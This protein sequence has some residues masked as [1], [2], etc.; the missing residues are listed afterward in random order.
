MSKEI[1]VDF[2]VSGRTFSIP[3]NYTIEMTEDIETISCRVVTNGYHPP[4][5][6]AMRSFEFRSIVT[7]GMH[8]P[9]FI[10]NDHIKN[11]NAELFTDKVFDTIMAEEHF[12]VHE[13]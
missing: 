8:T 11:V 6:L 1:V 4:V 13:H 3:V 10:D 7:D 2:E 9:L 12:M 5:W